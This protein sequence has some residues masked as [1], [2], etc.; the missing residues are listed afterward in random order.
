MVGFAT[1]HVKGDRA[2][3]AGDPLRGWVTVVPKCPTPRG[4]LTPKQSESPDPTITSR[5][6]IPHLQQS[7]EEY[8][9]DLWAVIDDIPS[10]LLTPDHQ[11]LRFKWEPGTVRGT[12]GPFSISFDLDTIAGDQEW[13]PGSFIEACVRASLTQASLGA[14]II[15]TATGCFQIYGPAI[16]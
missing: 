3:T 8:K 2:V 13:T 7:V 15:D 16:D 14:S 12:T 6:P 5:G 4:G 1:G 10:Y 9:V 11:E